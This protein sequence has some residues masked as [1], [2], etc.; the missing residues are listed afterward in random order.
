MLVYILFIAKRILFIAKRI[1]FIAK[2]YKKV[3]RNNL[4]L[5]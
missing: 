4:T 1:L 3:L 2:R 5:K